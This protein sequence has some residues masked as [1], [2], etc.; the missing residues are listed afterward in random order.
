MSEESAMSMC[1]TL[2]SA[3]WLKASSQVGAYERETYRKK[4][5]VRKEFV[6]FKY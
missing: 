6:D 5:N 1:V 2:V 4:R 3:V